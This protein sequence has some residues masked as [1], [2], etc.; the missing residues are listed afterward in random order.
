MSHNGYSNKTHYEGNKIEC[1][2]GI[3][4]EGLRALESIY[5]GHSTVKKVV[6]EH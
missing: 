5:E 3:A 6:P 4:Y 1:L 2:A